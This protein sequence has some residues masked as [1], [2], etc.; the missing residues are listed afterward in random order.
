MTDQTEAKP[1]TD[2]E[3]AEAPKWVLDSN[4][5]RAQLII[6]GTALTTMIDTCNT[7]A[8][9]G[10][11]PQTSVYVGGVITIAMSVLALLSRFVLNGG[12]TMKK[13]PKPPQPPLVP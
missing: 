8:P 13:P 2:T 9:V 12:L 1:E 4:I 11:P 5:V 7:A 3:T 6:I 10:S